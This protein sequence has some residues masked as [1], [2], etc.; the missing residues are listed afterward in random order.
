MAHEDPE[1]CDVQ[2]GAAIVFPDGA[3]IARILRHR[4]FSR[5]ERVAGPDLMRAM[6]ISAMDGGISMYFYGSSEETI[7]LLE[8]HN[9]RMAFVRAQMLYRL[10]YCYYLCGNMYQSNKLLY[11]LDALIINS[12]TPFMDIIKQ[13]KNKGRK[14]WLQ[15]KNNQAMEL[16][17]EYKQVKLW[18]TLVLVSLLMSLVSVACMYYVIYIR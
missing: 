17:K 1:Y 18:K 10:A 2:N 9:P 3:P 7:R 11:D 14:L 6:F 16:A 4:G 13:E 12:V 15:I 5:A 8:K